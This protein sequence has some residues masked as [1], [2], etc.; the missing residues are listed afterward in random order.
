MLTFEVSEF[1]I[2]T[3]LKLTPLKQTVYA[4]GPAPVPSGR[5]A[6]IIAA[7]ASFVWSTGSLSYPPICNPQS[8]AQACPGPN[9][10]ANL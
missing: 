3:A 1:K 10:L 4:V 7:F 8:P 6:L 5:C 2:V 9:S